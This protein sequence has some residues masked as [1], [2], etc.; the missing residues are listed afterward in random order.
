M[1]VSLAN[2]FDITLDAVERVAWRGEAVRLVPAALER[3]GMARAAFLRLI[4]DPDIVVYGVTSGYGQRAYLRFT[5]E[6]RQR[7]ARRAPFGSA[8]AFG[9]TLP[10]RVTRAMVL[11]RL[12]NFVE[13]HAA[14]TPALAQKVA[15][16]L[17]GA[18]LP[19]VPWQG[20]GGA[21]EILALSPLFGHLPAELEM[22]EKEVLSLINGSPCAAALVA[23]Q[24]IAFRRRAELAMRVMALSIEAFKA[25]LAA[26]DRALDELWG[27]PHEATALSGLRALLEGAGTD[28][29]AFQA[30]VSY[31]IIP[32]MLG[33]LQRALAQAGE[34]ARISLASVSD[35]PVFIP[36]DAAHPDAAHPNGRV[37]STGGYHNAM[38]WPA[39]DELAAA[40]A[41]LCLVAERHTDKM[42]S[43]RVSGLPDQLLTSPTD[44]RYMGTLG[45]VQVGYGEQARHAAQRT[46]M[47][48]PESGGYA[49]ND[50][51][52][53]TFLAWAKAVEAGEC[54]DGSLAML[55]VVSSQ[56]LQV[57]ERPAP[58]ALA[59]FLEEI[60]AVFPPIER[61]YPLGADLGRLAA[62]FTARVYAA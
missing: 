11:A 46:F 4:E 55:A 43:G 18:A 20:Q 27:D 48:G 26:Y 59:G 60:R 38:A 14:V 41:D 51:A 37:F 31:R 52:P 15:G 34:A 39:L 10:E 25:P 30:P 5:L 47:P 19:P 58:P 13:G 49:Q 7:H 22:G 54:L 24:A 6:E 61:G 9:R 42:L 50:V 40:A 32:R 53:P 12:A 62:W 8:T 23:D 17:D 45:M 36:P 33:R 21:G 57:T 16:M 28:R 56:A 1:T 2:R 29:R 44:D 3:I 35:N